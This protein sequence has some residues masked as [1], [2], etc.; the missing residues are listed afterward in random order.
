MYTVGVKH[1]STFVPLFH[2]IMQTNETT[3][4]EA[5]ET[6]LKNKK[7]DEGIQEAKIVD[8][9]RKTVG[10]YIDSYTDKIFVRKDILYVALANNALR[11]EL[12]YSRSK[13]V[14]AING[15]VGKKVLK[16]IVFS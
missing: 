12:F 16:E 4:K 7:M 10:G 15:L 2:D 5:I 13:I 1:F 11:N 3:L 8:A 14:Y 9:W 6:F